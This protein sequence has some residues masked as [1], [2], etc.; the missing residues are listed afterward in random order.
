MLI[1][2][3]IIADDWTED[4]VHDITVYSEFCDILFFCGNNETRNAK[5]TNSQVCDQEKLSQESM[6]QMRRF[7]SRWGA[8]IS[9]VSQ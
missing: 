3:L 4:D 9:D 8:F 6:N 7:S 5:E 2:K 1:L